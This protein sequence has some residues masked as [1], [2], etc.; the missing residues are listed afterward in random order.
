MLFFE[1]KAILTVI[2]AKNPNIKLQILYK[3]MDYIYGRNSTKQN[4]NTCFYKAA[5]IT[6][7]PQP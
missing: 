5:K 7:F 1:I 6:A 2:L 4:L 3:S